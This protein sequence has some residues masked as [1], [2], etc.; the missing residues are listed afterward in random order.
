MSSI[1]CR[2]SRPT[3]SKLTPGTIAAP[4]L[5]AP[6]VLNYTSQAYTTATNGGVGDLAAAGA[7]ANFRVLTQVRPTDLAKRSIISAFQDG[8]ILELI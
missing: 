1:S 7:S 8:L 6:L 3:N 2:T 5:P 4:Q